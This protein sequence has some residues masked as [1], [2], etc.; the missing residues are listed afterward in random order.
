MGDDTRREPGIAVFS[1][2]PGWLYFFVI[3]G[4]VLMLQAAITIGIFLIFL[5]DDVF[6]LIAGLGLSIFLLV[7]GC[8]FASY[9]WRRMRD[10]ENPIVIGPTG[11]HDRATSE[12]PIPWNDIRNLYVWDSVRGGP[13]VVYD[14]ADGAAERSAVF[15]RVRLM[16]RINRLFGYS[17]L[18]HSY[19]TDATIETL[20]A[21]ITPYAEARWRQ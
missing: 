3:F 6:F 9:G 2:R 10:P 19:G 16:A 21:A 13:L 7:I 20:V 14:L 17:Y 8:W 1:D 11:L 5:M 15:T 12:R 18:V 4:V